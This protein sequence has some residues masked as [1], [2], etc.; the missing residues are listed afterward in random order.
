MKLDYIIIF[1]LCKQY[2]IQNAKVVYFIKTMH[3]QTRT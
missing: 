1:T 3:L 2:E